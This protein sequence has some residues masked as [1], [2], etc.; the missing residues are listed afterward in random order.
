MR[1]PSERRGAELLPKPGLLPPPQ[2]HVLWR[3]LKQMDFNAGQWFVTSD[4]Q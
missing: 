3:D 2:F 1:P 4:P